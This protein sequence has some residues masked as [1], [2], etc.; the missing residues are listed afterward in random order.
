MKPSEF[1]KLLNRGE[2]FQL[3]HLTQVRNITEK[4]AEEYKPLIQEQRILSEYR[5]VFQDDFLEEQPPK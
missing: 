1:K 2:D 5:D 4:R 3:C